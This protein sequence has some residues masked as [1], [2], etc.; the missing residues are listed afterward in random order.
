MILGFGI[1]LTQALLC[2]CCLTLPKCFTFSEPWVP[3]LYTRNR[4]SPL[5]VL[6]SI[7]CSRKLL[8]LCPGMGT[9]QVFKTSWSG[10]SLQTG[11]S[12]HVP[13][14]GMLSPD[15]PVLCA[16]RLVPAVGAL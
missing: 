12:D 8:W 15:S 3:G 7:T 14:Q 2:T 6:E 10:Q 16:P 9:K 13:T 11:L 4:V 1:K 5:K